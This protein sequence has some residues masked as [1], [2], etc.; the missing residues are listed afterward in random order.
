MK[1]FIYILLNPLFPT[2]L[3]IGKT[4]HTSEKRAKEMYK[5]AGAGIPVEFIVAYDV[6]VSDCDLVEKLI[7]Q[8]L[9]KKRINQGREFFKLPLKDAVKMVERVITELAKQKKIEFSEQTHK[10]FSDR[11]WWDELSLVWKQIFKSHINIDYKPTE[12]DIL[13][14]IHSIIDNCQ[15]DKLRNLITKFIADNQ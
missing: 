13:S 9:A 2:Y 11:R 3:K 10:S 1:G 12:I 14:A 4:T 8:E 15:E 6:E 7:H 5:Q